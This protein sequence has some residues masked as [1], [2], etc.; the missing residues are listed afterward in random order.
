MS[1]QE[2]PPT[3][4]GNLYDASEPAKRTPSTGGRSSKWQPL[5]TVEPSPVGEH[6]PFSL[7]DSEDEKDTKPKDHNTDEGGPA[8]KDTAEAVAGDSN[9]PEGAGK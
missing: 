8:K 4:I 7:G 6:D 1:F 3:E 2:G 9:K 5:A